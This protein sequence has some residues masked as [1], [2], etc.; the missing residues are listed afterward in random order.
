MTR[1]QNN[2]ALDF[3]PVIALQKE[4]VPERS[5]PRF[6]REPRLHQIGTIDQL[7]GRNFNSNKDLGNDNYYI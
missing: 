1:S 6:Y 5:E 7:Q 4:V 3:R 2:A